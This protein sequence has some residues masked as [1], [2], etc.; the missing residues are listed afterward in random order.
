MLSAQKNQSEL[1]PRGVGSDFSV[2]VP[3][4]RSQVEER[5]DL[6]V[7]ATAKNCLHAVLVV[8]VPFAVR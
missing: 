8:L 3:G 1:N 2:W 5:T 7:R 4:I 6:D